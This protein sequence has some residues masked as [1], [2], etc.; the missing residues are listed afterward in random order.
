MW[1]QIP[2]MAVV[3]VSLSKTL[4]SKLVLFTQ[5]YKWVPVRVEVVI[6]LISPVKPKKVSHNGLYTPRELRQIAGM[7]L[8]Q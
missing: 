4:Y 2:A 3:R 6:M 8:A 7:I 1:V 5:E